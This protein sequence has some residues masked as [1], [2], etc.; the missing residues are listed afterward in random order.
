MLW[1]LPLEL[2]FEDMF[3]P[4]CDFPVFS[5]SYPRISGL[6]FVLIAMPFQTPIMNESMPRVLKGIE[7][8]FVVSTYLIPILSS[9][10]CVGFFFIYPN[11]SRKIG[12]LLTF[13]TS[14]IEIPSNSRILI[15]LKWEKAQVLLSYYIIDNNLQPILKS[16]YIYI[17][18]YIYIY[19]IYFILH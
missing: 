3:L 11:F 5:I 10:V 1:Y 4:F 14:I 8:R 9:I 19:A 16:Q 18:I 13:K 17:Y 6:C 7:Q 12:N 2:L 15:H